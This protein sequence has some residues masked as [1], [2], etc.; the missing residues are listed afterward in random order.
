MVIGFAQNSVEQEFNCSL[1]NKDLGFIIKNTG[2]QWQLVNIQTLNVIVP[3]DVITK[4][5]IVYE[6]E[7]D[8]FSTMLANAVQDS[9]LL[10]KDVDSV[11]VAPKETIKQ[12]TETPNE[13]AGTIE[14]VNSNN[15]APIV[16]STIKRK[17]RKNNKEGMEMIYIDDNGE[18][19]DT[20]RILIPADNLVKK[21]EEIETTDPV[22]VTP[23]KSDKPKDDSENPVYIVTEEEKLIIKEANESVDRSMPNS[24]C[25]NLATDEDFLKLRKKMVAEGNDEDM[26]KAAGKLFKTKCFTTDH[27][28]NL[29][30]LFLKDESKYMFFDAAYPF[31]SDTHL[32]SALEKQLSDTY[33]ITRFRALI[34]K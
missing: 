8:S 9:T 32:Y 21:T 19:K 34:N 11:I 20:I 3:G 22:I 13:N 17:L 33:Y 5:V 30:V 15:D 28:K 18:V 12:L 7:N 6:K 14:S 25:K 1:N 26:I 31:V 10:Q 23:E 29:S 27:I 2:E 24:D 4:P 16:R